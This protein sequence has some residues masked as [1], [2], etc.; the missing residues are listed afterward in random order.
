MNRLFL[1]CCAVLLSLSTSE[2]FPPD[3]L[4]NNPFIDD[5][6]YAAFEDRPKT[7]ADDLDIAAVW[8]KAV[9]D[10]RKLFQA[11]TASAATAGNF[12]TPVPSRW[13]GTLYNEFRDW[14]Y[15][16]FRD[17]HKCDFSE[18][19]RAF[20]AMGIDTRSAM[21]GGPNQCF[22]VD[23]YNGPTVFRDPSGQ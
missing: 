22:Q 16:D 15:N 13:V 14:G 5:T 1:I 21:N 23:H 11:M 10:G 18:A 7:K 2:I 17:D 4:A 3:S 6:H 8:F 19:A 20:A 9:C 12:I